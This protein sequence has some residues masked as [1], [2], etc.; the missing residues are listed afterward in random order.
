MK[1]AFKW[2]APLFMALCLGMAYTP[3]MAA[4]DDGST[5]Q[6]SSDGK[7]DCKKTP[8]DPRCKK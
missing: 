3:T 2:L 1:S 8:D 5:A 6:Q 7:P 4:P